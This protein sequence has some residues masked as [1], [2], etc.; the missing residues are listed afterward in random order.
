M[1][2]LGTRPR[3]IIT[4]VVWMDASPRALWLL[5]WVRE[6]VKKHVKK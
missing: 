4:R 6:H 5:K 1:I 2:L 3:A